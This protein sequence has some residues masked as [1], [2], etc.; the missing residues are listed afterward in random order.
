MLR[1]CDL[2]A[3]L[4]NTARPGRNEPDVRLPVIAG[5]TQLFARSEEVADWGT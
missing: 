2:D 4:P 1:L 3:V 5:L